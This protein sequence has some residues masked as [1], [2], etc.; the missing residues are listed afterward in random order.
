[1]ATGGTYTTLNSS[2][3]IPANTWTHVAATY[4]GTTLRIYRNGVQVGTRALSG[5]LVNTRD[6]LKIGGNAVWSEW[7]RGQID[8]VRVWSAART[9]AQVT[10]D[11]NAAI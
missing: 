11:M 7:F 6:P 1:V 9:A 8:E 4:D 5:D 2:Q 3:T 10:A